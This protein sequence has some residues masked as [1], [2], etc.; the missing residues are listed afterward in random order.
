MD[1]KLAIQQSFSGFTLI[2][3]LTIFIPF[4]W[5]LYALF[6]H[7][8]ARIPGPFL[9]SVS[10]IWKLQRAIR[11]TLHREILKGH[12]KYGRSFRVAPNEVAIADPEAIKIIYALN[13]GFNKVRKLYR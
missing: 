11:G 10:P 4:G 7:P 9:A 1:F 6:F 3:G 12:Q 13:S 8:L 2:V 5:I